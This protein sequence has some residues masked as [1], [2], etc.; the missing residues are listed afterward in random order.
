MAVTYGKYGMSVIDSGSNT[1]SYTNFTMS[2]GDSNSNYDIV[3]ANVRF[4][5]ATA[6]Q[7]LLH[8]FRAGLTSYKNVAYRA[9]A[10][11]SSSHSSSYNSTVWGQKA[12][13]MNGGNYSYA[14]FTIKNMHS[15]SN[16]FGDTTV[17]CRYLISTSISGSRN[18]RNDYSFA[19]V[20]VT[21]CPDK[22]ESYF[23]NGNIT[24][25][26]FRVYGLGSSD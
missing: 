13:S 26:E 14:Q 22:I 12:T 19:R 10:A 7:Y 17:F 18:W 5:G 1:G 4:T 9:A 23:Q 16:P 6:N 24:G 11:G 25:Y 8:R 15:D 2:C 20:I 21:G 3:Q